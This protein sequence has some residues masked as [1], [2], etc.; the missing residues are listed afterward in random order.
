MM[1]SHRRHAVLLVLVMGVVALVAQ[2]AGVGASSHRAVK[3]KAARALTLATIPEGSV[4]DIGSTSIAKTSVRASQGETVR[5]SGRAKVT[6]AAVGRAG[7]AQVVCGIRYSRAKD[8]SWSLG[9]PY[10]TVTLTRRGASDS[11]ALDRSF[12]APANDTYKMS[13]ACHV[14]AP[15]KGA[16]VTATGSMRSALGLPAGAATPVE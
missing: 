7:A 15:A 1:L 6:A 10:E 4:P 9:V 5:M 2:L 8:A 11:V 14:S 12:E 13:M 3:P 16:K